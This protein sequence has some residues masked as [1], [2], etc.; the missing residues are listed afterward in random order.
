MGHVRASM[1]AAVAGVRDQWTAAQANG[2]YEGQPWLVG[3]NYVPANAINQLDMWQ[4]ATFDPATIDKALGWAAGLGMNT[5]RVYLHNLLGEEDAEGFTQRID[6]FL[7]IAAKHGIKPMFVLF[8]SCWDPDPRLGPQHPPIPGGHNSG[9]VQAPGRARLEDTAQ[10]DKLEAYVKGVVGAFADDERILA[11]D[12]WN[13]PD[14]DARRYPRHV[15]KQALVEG[16]LD[17]VF[18]W[19]RSADPA[20]PLTSGVWQPQNDDWSSPATQNGIEKIQLAESDIISF[21]DYSWPESFERR[22]RQ[23]QG[24]GRPIL[25]TEYLS[26]GSGS[27]FDTILPLGK[28][29]NIAM[30]NWGFVDGET[31]TRFPWDSW[32][33]P[34]TL[35]EPMVWFHDVMRAD[36]TPYRERE[37]QLIRRLT[38]AP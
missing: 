24:Y 7:A 11:W 23:L 29:Y 3:A 36:G 2:W 18:A 19:A 15:G 28:E 34:Y 5:M 22:V 9:W 1:L 27:T 26:R 32:Q 6:A 14:N 25:C 8:D 10:Y 37:A 20:Q 30:F 4:A 31:Q 12:V 35:Q 21:H 13:E 33:R 38:K 17:D 16:L